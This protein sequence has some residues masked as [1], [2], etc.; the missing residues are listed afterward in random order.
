MLLLIPLVFREKND[1]KMLQLKRSNLNH[2][3]VEQEILSATPLPNSSVA[4][5]SATLSKM[6]WFSH[7]TEYVPGISVLQ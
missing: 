5:K 6:T 7:Y 3:C 1:M 2:L 4:V